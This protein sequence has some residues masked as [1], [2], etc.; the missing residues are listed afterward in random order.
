MRKITKCI[1]LNASPTHNNCNEEYKR[2]TA[3]WELPNSELLYNL[4][5]K[6]LDPLCSQQIVRKIEN[7][8]FVDSFMFTTHMFRSQGKSSSSVHNV[9]SRCPSGKFNKI[10]NIR[11]IFIQ[12]IFAICY[13]RNLFEFH[14]LVRYL[15]LG[16]RRMEP[17][18]KINKVVCQI[19]ESVLVSAKLYS[20]CDIFSFVQITMFGMC[21]ANK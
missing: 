11:E 18:V 10:V 13:E 21:R 16:P 8:I 15:K 3:N 17:E 2:I 5:R 19:I 9:I 1:Y 14:S 4:L 20:I 6:T 12:Y 7:R